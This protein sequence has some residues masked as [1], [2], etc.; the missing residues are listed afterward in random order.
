MLTGEFR[1]YI[2]SL[3]AGYPCF[4][5]PSTLS[6][7]E[8]VLVDNTVK[9]DGSSKLRGFLKRLAKKAS[10]KASQ[11]SKTGMVPS[12]QDI[13]EPSTPSSSMSFN[14]QLP[15]SPNAKV[16]EK[17]ADDGTRCWNL[18]ISR[19]FFDAK[20]NDD[21]SKAIKARIQVR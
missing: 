4:L 7:Q 12:K 20:M 10:V 21:I 1:S 17:F 8:H 2:A 11:E 3:K 19:L 16:D 18:L 14:S 13:K 15:D 6:S 5:G 9:T